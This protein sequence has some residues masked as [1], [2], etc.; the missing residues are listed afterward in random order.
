MLVAQADRV[1]AIV[2]SRD[3]VFAAYGMDVLTA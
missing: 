3:T 1:G 2:V